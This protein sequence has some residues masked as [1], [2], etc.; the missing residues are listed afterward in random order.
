MLLTIFLSRL[1]RWF[2]AWRWDVILWGMFF[3]N[4]L[5]FVQRFHW[6][7]CTI[8]ARNDDKTRRRGVLHIN[9]TR[10]ISILFSWIETSLSITIVSSS[11]V[12]AGLTAAVSFNSLDL[13]WLHS[14]FKQQAN[15]NRERRY[16][17]CQDLT[18]RHL[19]GSKRLSRRWVGF[20]NIHGLNSEG[21]DCRS[22]RQ[23]RSQV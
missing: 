5:Q 20:Y 21:D 8:T 19:H 10:Y 15:V 17:T 14:I 9:L 6:W 7:I 3:T 12:S 23:G 2:L 4:I 1:K 18:R 22:R 13:N 11:G 16:L